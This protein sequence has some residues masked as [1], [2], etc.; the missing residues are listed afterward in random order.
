[1][2]VL[3]QSQEKLTGAVHMLNFLFLLVAASGLSILSSIGSTT[4]FHSTFK[5]SSMR[6]V[7]KLGFGVPA[8]VLEKGEGWT[9]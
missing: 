5:R 9:E 7:S 8:R 1:M 3:A 6:T 2:S 4:W